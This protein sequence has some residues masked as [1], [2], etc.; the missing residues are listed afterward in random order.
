MTD[1]QIPTALMFSTDPSKPAH[2][3]PVGTSAPVNAVGTSV[4][5]PMTVGPRMGK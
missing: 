2:V 5:H 3:T 1:V 4:A